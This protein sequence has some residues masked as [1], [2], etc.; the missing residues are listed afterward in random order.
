M[1]EGNVATP[2]LEMRSFVREDSEVFPSEALTP[3]IGSPF[4]SVYEL[5]G[6]REFFDPEQEAYT[7]LVQDL[8]DEEFDEALFE[9]MV[10]ARGLHEEHMVSSAQSVEGERLLNQHFNQLIRESEGAVTAF[11]REFGAREVTS[12]SESELDAFAEGYA[13]STPLNPEFEEFFGKLKKKLSGLAKKAV[14]F[15][16][17]AGSFALKLGLGPVLNKLKGL[18]KPLL[19]KVLQMAIGKLPEAVRPAAQQLADRIFNRQPKSADGGAPADAAASSSDASAAP[20]EDAGAGAQ[21]AAGANVTDI[22]QEF[23]Q[24]VANLFLAADE[25]ELE[26]EVA[27]ARSDERGPA[28]PVYAELDQARERFINE[29]DQLREGEDPGPAIQNF[30][31]AV[32]PAL[33]MGIKLIGRGRVVGFLANLLAKLIAKLIGP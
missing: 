11:E 33:R 31:P 12:L 7:T 22:Q 6:H 10:S 4:V 23:D 25:V 17:K 28:V 18:I 29:L 8:Y 26:L 13:S 21:A 9:L 3:A 5:D 14:G 15:A 27:R 19:N 32:L 24:Q 16:K 20:A 2:F 1:A 30:L